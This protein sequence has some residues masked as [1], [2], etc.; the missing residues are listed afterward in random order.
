MDN[1][2]LDKL[3][4]DV[5]SSA[6]DFREASNHA[7]VTTTSTNNSSGSNNNSSEFGSMSGESARVA[8]RAHAS[9]GGRELQIISLFTFNS[10]SHAFYGAFSGPLEFQA[11]SYLECLLRR[12]EKKHFSYKNRLCF[13]KMSGFYVHVQTLMISFIKE[14]SLSDFSAVSFT[15]TESESGSHKNVRVR[16]K[17]PGSSDGKTR[18]RTVLNEKQL[19][20]L[21]TFFNANPR[22][23]ALMKEQLVEMTGLSPRV[24]RVWF[25]NKRCKHN[26][27][28]NALKIQMEQEKVS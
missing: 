26:K 25:Q 15:E 16:G 2:A 11:L 22:P 18:V 7:V 19:H 21:S 8:G 6:I 5:D 23:D 10:S 13:K 9:M 28:T 17:P 20:T 27:K 1:D 14:L 24:I 12:R 3:A 4:Q